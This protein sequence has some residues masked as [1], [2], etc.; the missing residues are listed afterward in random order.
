M[1]RRKTAGIAIGVV[2]LTVAAVGLV[3]GLG[4]GDRTLE[5][6]VDQVRSDADNTGD[7]NV[8]GGGTT[9][10]AAAPTPTYLE[11]SPRP[12]LA[13]PAEGPV[14]F[15]C[16]FT[17]PCPLDQFVQYRDGFVVATDAGRSDHAVADGATFENPVCTPPEETRAWTRIE[18][19]QLTYR[20]L[21]GGNLEAAHQMSVAP[22]VTGYSFTAASPDLVFDEVEHISFEV[23]MTSVGVRNFWEVAVIPADEAWV[24]GMPC[25]PDLPCNDSYD[26]DDIDAIGF[27]NQNYNG[28]GFQIATPA[29]PDGYIFVR[30]SVVSLPNGDTQYLQCDDESFCFRA[31]VHQGQQDVRARFEVIVEQRDDGLW[32][33]QEETDGTFH[34]VSLEGERLPEGPVRVV[35]KFHGYTPTK[36]GQGPGFDGNL[37]ASVGGFTWHWDDL[38][39]VA[40]AAVPSADYY[41][42]LNPERFTTASVGPC[43]AFAQ[44]QRDEDGRTVH[45][46]FSCPE[47]YTIEGDTP[48]VYG[49][50]DALRVNR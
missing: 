43:I 29:K 15:F 26:Y 33:G 1:S 20:C 34:W 40:A 18:P 14:R 36:S 19:H 10:E 35:L 3:F 12:E 39:V 41:G 38:E 9:D 23:N 25:I 28:S 47:G 16:D 48:V 6:A 46:L 37:S 13:T 32:F 7:R 27:G 50:I 2:A 42:D 31:S 24:D 4:V 44:G 17:S 22:D 11:P 30:D 49:E 45:P 21:P 5:R 8:A